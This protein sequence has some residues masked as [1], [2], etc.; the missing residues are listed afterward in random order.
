[1][2][3]IDVRYVGDEPPPPQTESFGYSIEISAH[4]MTREEANQALLQ[5]QK[6]I[7]LA[8]SEELVFRGEE[9]EGA[10]AASALTEEA[11]RQRFSLSFPVYVGV[12]TTE[13]G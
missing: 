9:Y 6:A 7:E 8:L 3:K 13:T 1:M 12:E 4:R 2:P 11:H 10:G 5:A